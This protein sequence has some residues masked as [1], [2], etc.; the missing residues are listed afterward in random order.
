MSEIQKILDKELPKETQKQ[1]YPPFYVP[2]HTQKV[3]TGMPIVSN[4][5][6]KELK[7]FSPLHGN[8]NIASNNPMNNNYFGLYRPMPQMNPSNTANKSFNRRY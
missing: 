5:P 7:G 2:K 4:D 3:G 6:P 8:K 1:T